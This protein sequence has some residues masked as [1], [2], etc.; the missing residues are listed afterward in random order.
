MD[1]LSIVVQPTWRDFLVELISTNQMDPWG[2]D[3]VEIADKYLQKVRQLTVMDLRIPANVILASAILLRF[4]ADSLS[5]DEEPAEEEF[6]E[7]RQLVSEAIPELVFRANRPRNRRVTL[8]EL[9][10]A[11]EHVLK[12][13]P[14]KTLAAA[15]KILSLE[16]PKQD[17]GERMKKVYERA[18]TMRDT[19]GVLVFSSLLHNGHCTKNGNGHNGNGH[20]HCTEGNGNGHGVEGNGNGNGHDGNGHEGNG[21]GA[22]GCVNADS[23]VSHL[24]PVLHLV[25]EKKMLAW[26]E[27]V[28]GEI[29]LRVWTDD[30][31]QAQQA[32][33]QGA[34]GNAAGQAMEQ[35]VGKA[36]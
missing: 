27:A 22:C 4:K 23:M 15:P 17:M 30:E 21:N 2:L 31:I 24:V 1:L 8:E 11:V 7:E 14:R 20:S 28:F 5:F 18:I 35:R 10:K 9:M 16:V 32:E 6:V 34:P 25:Q 3:L 36:A 13:G 33:V 29:F 19:E 26:Q 12:D